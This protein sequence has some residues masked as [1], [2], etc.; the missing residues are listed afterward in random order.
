MLCLERDADQV[1]SPPIILPHSLEPPARHMRLIIKA[2][3]MHAICCRFLP[4]SWR[5]KHLRLLQIAPSKQRDTAKREAR[6]AYR[7]PV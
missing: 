5:H 1:L 7:P 3:S 2:F 6:L 4:S